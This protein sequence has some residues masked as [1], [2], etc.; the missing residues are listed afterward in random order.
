MQAIRAGDLYFLQSPFHTQP[1]DTG[2]AVEKRL[3]YLLGTVSSR[4]VVVI[5]PPAWWDRFNTCTVIPA[6]SHG[7]PAIVYK[8]IDR[9][10]GMTK[11]DYPFVPHNPH[12][13]PVSRLG[14]FMG[15]MTDEELEPL[16]YAYKWIHDPFMQMDTQNY[17]VPEV[18]RDVMAKKIPPHSW[19]V[20]KDARAGVDIRI[21]KDMELQSETNPELN[22]FNIGSAMKTKI[23]PTAER[24]LNCDKIYVPT[25]NPLPD[26]VEMGI[27]E[28]SCPVEKSFPPS[29]FDT[30]TLNRVASRFT[31]SDAYYNNDKSIRTPDILTASEISNIRCELTDSEFNEI[32]QFYKK[33]TPLDAYILGPRLPLEVLADITEMPTSKAVALKRLCNYMRDLPCEDY[34]NRVKELEDRLESEKEE[35]SEVEEEIKQQGANKSPS[36]YVNELQKVKPY[37]NQKSIMSMPDDVARL[38]L[39]MPMYLIKRN[40]NGTQFNKPYAKAMEYYKEKLSK[41]PA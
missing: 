28:I 35:Q 36:M 25:E 15:S 18:Y 40:Y 31:I 11:A 20:N 21:T 26:S 14:K 8:L 16:L 41:T 19:R 7:E 30:E 3:S 29:I 23:S 38:F 37:L 2:A 10:G 27:N 24:A 34:D 33:M 5:R 32:I 4:P 6:L 1:S 17:P 13:I 39:E 12:T 22:R 9:Y